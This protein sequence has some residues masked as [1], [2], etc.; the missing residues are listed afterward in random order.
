[1]PTPLEPLSP[2][3]LQ[4]SAAARA[5][6]GTI[7]IRRSGPPLGDD[8]L[9][10]SGRAV[11][12]APLDPPLDPVSTGVGV[13]IEG[14]DGERFLDVVVPGGAGWKVNGRGDV[15]KFV[16]PSD[17]APG[18]VARLVVKD[19]SRRTPGLVSFALRAPR[20]SYEI[21]PVVFPLRGFA[22][23]DP[24][25]AETGQCVDVSFASAAE[26]RAAN[27]AITCR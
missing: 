25:I 14:R 22:I 1:V 18:D 10:F 11:L 7:R 21:D 2:C 26:C 3:P 6:R 12:P 16:A 27:R 19:R 8:L 17:A 4:C 13:V 23:L 20:G 15:W 24:P 9:L 5:T